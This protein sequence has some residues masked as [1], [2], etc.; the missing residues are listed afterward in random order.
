[1]SELTFKQFELTRGYLIKNVELV[2][3]EAADVQPAGFKIP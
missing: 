1:M 2:S 3:N